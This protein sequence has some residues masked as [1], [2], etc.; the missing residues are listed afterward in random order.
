MHVIGNGRTSLTFA[1]RPGIGLVCI[2]DALRG[3]FLSRPGMLFEFAVNNGPLLQSDHDLHLECV[4]RSVDGSTLRLTTAQ[5]DDLSFVVAAS[6]APRAVI[7]RVVVTNHSS[8]HVFLRMVL[9]KISGVVTPGLRAD[10]MGAVPQE[11]GGIAHLTDE[12]RLGMP[13]KVKMNVGLPLAFNSLELATVY[14]GAG[15]GG[16]FFA[17][18]DG[19]LDAG[20]PPLQFVLSDQEVVGFWTGWIAPGATA[21][22]PGLAIGTYDGDWH[23]A[24]DFAAAVHPS[25]APSPPSPAWLREQGAIYTFAG[26]GAG[27]IYLDQLG[28]E[29]VDGAVWLTTRAAGLALDAPIPSYPITVTRGGFAAVGGALVTEHQ[30]NDQLDVFGVGGDGAVWMTWVTGQGAWRDGVADHGLPVPVTPAAYV[31]A[32]ADLA[33]ARQGDDQ[34]DV[35]WVGVDGAVWM[36]WVK[37]QG[38]WRDGVADHGLPVRVTPAGYAPPGAHLAAA[39]QGDD[40]LD[41]FW[42]RDD[43]AVW[44]TWATGMGAWRDG[45]EGRGLPVPVT[46]AAYVPA[47]AHL[48]VAR[49]GD[50]QLDVFWAGVDG[51]V[52]MTWATGQGAWRDGVDDDGL[53]VRVTPAGYAPSGAHLAAAHQGD[54]Q[55]D[56]F[57]AR[58][59]GAVWV[60]WVVGRGAWRDG[61][62]GNGLPM[63]VTP[64]N[65]AVAGC[66]LAAVRR[67]ADELAVFWVGIDWSVLTTWARGKGSWRDGVLGHGR[68]K[69]LTEPGQ[70]PP[71]SPVAAAIQTGGQLDVFVVRP[72]RFRSFLQLPELLEEARRFGTSI[73]YLWDYWEGAPDAPDSPYWNKGDY[74]PR[75]AL[76][77]EE[78]LIAGIRAVHAASGRVLCYL[79]PFIIYERS[80]IAQ[81]EG[82]KWAARDWHD[83]PY[84]TEPKYDRNIAMVATFAPWQDHVVAT[85]ER[86][87]CKY[88][89][90]GI[91]LDSVAW[92]MNQHMRAAADV[93]GRVSTSLEYSRAMLA[94]TDRVREAVR[95]KNRNAVVIGETTSGPIASHWDGGLG[96]DFSRKLYPDAPWRHQLTG[97]PVRYARPGVTWFANGIDL[98]E[99]HQVFAAG[100]NLALCPSWPHTSM[101]DAAD[102]IKQLVTLR[103]TYK[104]AL[105]YGHQAYQP[106]T[107]FDD[108]V[109]YRYRGAAHQLITVVNIGNDERTVDLELRGELD[110]GLW[111]DRMRPADNYIARSDRLPG[112]VMAARSIRVLVYWGRLPIVAHAIRG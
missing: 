72:G 49:Q 97:S 3:P 34:L 103:Q 27:S 18:V 52:W 23:E 43:G 42:V 94:L 95:G 99:L 111:R 8:G 66:P 6:A 61:V 65:W 91:L 11:M 13:L 104:D 41:V 93:S 53:P 36:T 79:E 63:R 12:V 100:H 101:L 57:W 51:S 16:I 19:D 20:V 64:Q 47:G 69:A 45:I 17:D 84:I 5:R 21:Y 54:D 2:D 108:V 38:A 81:Q 56:V 105:V 10:R 35:F 33:A 31:P 24:A 29:I 68:P 87:V 48:A 30:G 62:A 67:S 7:V 44:M 82:A 83:K 77:G 80:V 107:G 70:A 39:R 98:N 26:G 92:Q 88:G 71:G 15:G 37:G 90:D 25:V 59:D 102:H 40:Q 86:L 96:G 78:A 60:T 112:V 32:A 73:V 22:V 106:R 58:D 89:F 9:P 85:A 74:I 4:A 110:G 55:L 46:P 14:D 1:D 50:D 75:G 28:T 109:A 76:G